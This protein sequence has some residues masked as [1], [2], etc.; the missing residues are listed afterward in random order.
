MALAV[1]WGMFM[2]H[3]EFSE[4]PYFAEHDVIA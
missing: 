2:R 1:Q 4:H 3:L